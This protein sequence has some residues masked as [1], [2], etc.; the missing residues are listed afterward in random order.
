M[1][2]SAVRG[3]DLYLL[4]EISDSTLAYDLRRKANLY[5]QYGVREYWV[6]DVNAGAVHVHRLDGEWPAAPVPLTTA[7]A[8]SLIPGLSVTI[9]DLLR[10]Y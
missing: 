10:T 4:I 3:P 5:R 9:A 6:V 1:A 7:V 8:P 2:P